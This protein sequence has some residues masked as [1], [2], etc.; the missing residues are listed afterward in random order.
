MSVRHVLVDVFLALGVL[1]ILLSCLGMLAFRG[2][3][4]RL[5]FSSPAVL[6]TLCVTVAV[7]LKESFSLVGDKTILVAVFLMVASP[8]VTHAIARAAR[9]AEHGDWVIQPEESIEIEEK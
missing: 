4:E 5:H 2:V 9:I 8:M 3:Y 6:G 7:M 1:L